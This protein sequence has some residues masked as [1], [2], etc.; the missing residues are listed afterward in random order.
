MRKTLLLLSGVIGI[1]T[2][3]FLALDLLNGG[4]GISF[5]TFILWTAI[6]GIN[7]FVTIKVK[8]NFVL[9]LTLTIGNLLV[10]LSLLWTGQIGWGMVEWLTLV[11]VV[12]CIYVWLT[13]SSTSTI[14]ISTITITIA[15]IPQLI[16]AWNNP[17]A[18]S[19]PIWS[20]FF[21]SSVCS[22]FAGKEWTVKERLYATA[23]ASFYA[24][25]IMLAL[26]RF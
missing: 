26:G 19:I 2:F 15:G 10:A 21:V 8:G 22:V 13:A 20:G 14:I 9:P 4:T 23:R 6:V 17:T 18:V 3:I 5:A 1:L 12:I 24:A 7:T 25:I 11:L 16:T